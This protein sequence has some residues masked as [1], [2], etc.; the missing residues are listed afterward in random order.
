MIP[1]FYHCLLDKTV[2]LCFVINILK[3]RTRYAVKIIISCITTIQ[4]KAAVNN[5]IVVF[6]IDIKAITSHSVLN[7]IVHV[8]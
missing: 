5:Y 7:I 8:I 4:C 1:L 3:L 6:S 2:L